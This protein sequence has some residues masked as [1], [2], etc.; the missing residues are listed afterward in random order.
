MRRI[1]TRFFV[2]VEGEGESGFIAW[3][4]GV[5]DDARLHVHYDV[6][7][8]GGGDPLH[9]VQKALREL[10]QAQPGF[11]ARMLLLDSDR[12]DAD[13]E[14]GERARRLAQ[15]SGV[16]LY[17][18]EP[19]HEV[20]LLRLHVGHENDEPASPALRS[21][22]QVWPDYAKPNSRK[23]L[24]DRFTTA[25]LHRARLHDRM[26]DDLLTALHLTR[27]VTATPA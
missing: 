21:L 9:M 27:A 13:R 5:A 14:R 6:R 1:R 8:L 16:G 17:L 11:A 3:L 23:N 26:L 19:D 15:R 12:F 4:R 25:D 2:G 7:V 18:Q 20:V 24:A 22:R 10:R